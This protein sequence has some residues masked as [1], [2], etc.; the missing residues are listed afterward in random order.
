MQEK[1]DWCIYQCFHWLTLDARLWLKNYKDFYF[2]LEFVSI[3]F[4][5]KIM[6]CFGNLCFFPP[7]K[8]LKLIIVS[9]NQNWCGLLIHIYMYV[10]E[11]RQNCLK[12]AIPKKTGRRHVGARVRKRMVCPFPGLCQRSPHKPWEH[13]SLVSPPKLGSRKLYTDSHHINSLLPSFQ[14]QPSTWN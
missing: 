11:M 7:G 12:S 1:K 6:H 14:E 4:L 13:S 10:S 2:L 3:N 8:F 9:K 5:D